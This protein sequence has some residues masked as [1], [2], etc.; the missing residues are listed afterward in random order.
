[1]KKVIAVLLGS[2]IAF[3]PVAAYGDS[4]DHSVAP[5]TTVESRGYSHQKT[6]FTS[7][8]LQQRFHIETSGSRGATFIK[9]VPNKGNPMKYDVRFYDRKH[10]DGGDGKY[11]GF[12]VMDK[13]TVLQWLQELEKDPM[14]RIRAT[15]AYQTRSKLL[16]D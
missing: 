5:S 3:G 4:H 10:A 13:A 8:Q 15:G 9:I 12:I 2:T 16:H 11:L 6:I 1:M 7:E 14:L